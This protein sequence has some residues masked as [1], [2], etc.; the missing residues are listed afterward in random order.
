MNHKIILTILIGFIFFAACKDD[1]CPC[2]CPSGTGI[3]SEIPYLETIEGTKWR[4]HPE[5]PHGLFQ[6]NKTW[7][8]E[9]SFGTNICGENRLQLDDDEPSYYDNAG[10]K[11]RL[12]IDIE[13][14]AYLISF[15]NNGCCWANY[16]GYIQGDTMYVEHI[17]RNPDGTI[18]EHEVFLNRWVWMV[19]VRE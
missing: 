12:V 4:H 15:K 6:L 2:N 3:S 18:T 14:N 13:Y 1:C 19:R 17:P 16:S 9:L 5:S 11:S 7:G 8:W 10:N